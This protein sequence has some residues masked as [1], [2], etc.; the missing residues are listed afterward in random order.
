MCAYVGPLASV[1]IDSSFQ[2]GKWQQLR[3]IASVDVM[4]N[5]VPVPQCRI[6][7][8]GRSPLRQKRHGKCAGEA[9][10][11]ARPLGVQAAL[12]ASVALRAPSRPLDAISQHQTP[13]GRPNG[14]T[15]WVILLRGYVCLAMPPR[16][17]HGAGMIGFTC[18]LVE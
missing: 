1:Q 11:S 17:R 13:L 9:G 5:P 15:R 4:R 18:G 14:V 6:A 12:S 2:P 16:H 7:L 10:G 8:E 3:Q